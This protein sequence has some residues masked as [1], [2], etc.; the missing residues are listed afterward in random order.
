M[1]TNL[2]GTMTDTKAVIQ[3]PRKQSFSM[4]VDLRVPCSIVSLLILCHFLDTFAVFLDTNS[5][6]FK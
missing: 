2:T 3:H 1:L 5:C 6:F 4:I